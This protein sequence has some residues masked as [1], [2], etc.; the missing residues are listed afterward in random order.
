MPLCK[1]AELQARFDV[2][3][4]SDRDVVERCLADNAGHP[5]V[6]DATKQFVDRWDQANWLDSG[7]VERIG[8]WFG[9]RQ[10]RHVSR[11]LEDWA[12]QGSASP[13]RQVFLAGIR[14]GIS[15]RESHQA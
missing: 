8:R 9:R 14:C 13:A 12:S 7:S 10:P 3:R 6:L 4:P 2:F 11:E 15:L 5:V 1:A